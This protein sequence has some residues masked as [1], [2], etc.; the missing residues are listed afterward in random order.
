MGRWE[1]LG[2]RDGPEHSNIGTAVA[3]GP[4]AQEVETIYVGWVC[5]S[6]QAILWGEVRAVGRRRYVRSVSGRI[7]SEMVGTGDWSPPCAECL[8]QTWTWEFSR[9]VRAQNVFIQG[10]LVDIGW[11]KQRRRARTAAVLPYST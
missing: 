11:W 2:E 5:I 3:E 10:C 9:K 6:I 7:T 1:S 4:A 8:R